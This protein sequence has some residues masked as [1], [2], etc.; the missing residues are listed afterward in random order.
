MMSTYSLITL[1]N[2][3]DSGHTTICSFWGY[4]GDTLLYGLT[5]I[6]LATAFGR[7]F[8]VGISRVGTL[9][10]LS[11]IGINAWIDIFLW[12]LSEPHDDI[13]NEPHSH[14]TPAGLG[15]LE[16]YSYLHKAIGVCVLY[17]R[18]TTT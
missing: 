7:C 17:P 3:V 2:N 9:P 13:S 16:A 10:L 1:G 4:T 8:W 11:T 5:T 12:T 15:S 14:Y 6:G 18:S